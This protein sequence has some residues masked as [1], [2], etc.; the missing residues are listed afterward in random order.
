MKKIFLLILTLLG[1]GT[2]A[3][4]QGDVKPDWADGY[5]HELQNSY[6]EVVSGTGTD[7]VL[8]RN[9]A[10]RVIVERRNLATGQR[11]NVQITGDQ[12][13]LSESSELTVMARILDE[14]AEHH[15]SGHWV[16]YLLVQTAKNPTFE[17]EPVTVT[18]RY[19]FGL[20]T[21]VPG[22]AQIDKGQTAKGIAFIAAEVATVGGII[23]AEGLRSDY[24]NRINSTHNAAQK[25]DYISKA[26]TCTNLRN[27][28]IAGAAAV[29]VWNLV[30]ALASKGP[31]R[32][33][34]ADMNLTPWATPDGMGLTMNF[35][36]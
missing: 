12:V 6:I 28:C 33:Q 16:V 1:F 29:Y 8:A 18:D 5:F 31:K 32:I 3:A 34:I 13:T 9:N 21:L 7:H 10:A 11:V 14:Y 15:G 35:N 24:K 26:N 22:M 23:V 36:F 19:P 27:V 4:Q 20:K 2:A 30:D 25:A 17:F